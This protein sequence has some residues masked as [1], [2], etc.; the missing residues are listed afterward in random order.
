MSAFSSITPFRFSLLTEVTRLRVGSLALALCVSATACKKDEPKNDVT[1]ATSAIPSAT[2]SAGPSA[3]ACEA[4]GGEVADAVTKKF[5]PRKSGNYCVDPTG[6]TRTYGER[7]KFSMDEVCTTA[8]DGECE[9]Y[10]SYQLKR[11]T[12]FRYVDAAGKG[13][14]VEVKLSEFSSPEGAYGMFTKRVVAEQDPAQPKFPRAVE[15]EGAGA[16]GSGVSYLWKGAYLAELTYLNEEETPDAF[17]KSADVILPVIMK[18][19]AKLLPEPKKLPTAALALPNDKRLPNGLQFFPKGIT[20]FGASP[21][22]IGYFKSAEKRYRVVAIAA[23]DAK[24]AFKTLQAKAGAVA[25]KDVGEEAVVVV[26]QEAPGRPKCEYV[27]GRKGAQIL[28][29]GDEDL[30]LDAK[31]PADQQAPLKLTKDEKIAFVRDALK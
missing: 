13:S 10:K 27:F 9:V 20:L 15:V 28:G 3:N 11:L 19:T 17:T 22:G 16:I 29:V 30:V 6:E 7:G 5:I 2:G 26:L 31:A 14:T 1:P 24:A 8:F 18:D 25:V 4:G 12:T 23:T 21:T